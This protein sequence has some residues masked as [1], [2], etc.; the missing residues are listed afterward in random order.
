MTILS[1]LQLHIF[2]GFYFGGGVTAM[3][4][5]HYQMLNKEF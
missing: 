5:E 2:V 4:R 3:L 1:S